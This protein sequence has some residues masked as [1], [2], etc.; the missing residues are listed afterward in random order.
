MANYEGILEAL[1]NGEF[2][3]VQHTYSPVDG[4][5]KHTS[6]QTVMQVNGSEIEVVTKTTGKSF[7]GK[8]NNWYTEE[9]VEYLNDNEAVDFI[10]QRPYYFR[11][12]RPDLF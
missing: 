6:H 1:N 7:D 9:S 8:E 12:V 4:Y 5:Q 3:G 11:Q 2:D 10:L